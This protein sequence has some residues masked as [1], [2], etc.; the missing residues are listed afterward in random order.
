MTPE[1]IKTKILA[2]A[3]KRYVLVELAAKDNLGNLTIDVLQALDEINDL[4]DEFKKTFP[5]CPIG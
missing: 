4:L 2:I 5:D 1:I 3:S